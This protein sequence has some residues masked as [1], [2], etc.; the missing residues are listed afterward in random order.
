MFLGRQALEQ[1]PQ[2]SG[3][4]MELLE[5]KR[6]LNSALR[7]MAWLMLCGAKSWTRWSLWVPSSGGYS[8]IL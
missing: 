1:A 4:G 6:Y 7:H 8:M 3:H 2:V 5:F